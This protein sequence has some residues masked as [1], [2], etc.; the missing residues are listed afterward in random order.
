[1][2]EDN[3]RDAIRDLNMFRTIRAE[4][5]K[6]GYDCLE[7]LVFAP[8]VKDVIVK[9]MDGMITAR[10]ICHDLAVST[11]AAVIGEKALGGRDQS[12]LRA[13]FHQSLSFSIPPPTLYHNYSRPGAYSELVFGIP[14]ADL[15]TNLTRDKV[16]KVMMMCIKEVEKRGLQAKKIYSGNPLDADV[17]QLRHR[18]EN[19]K[20][21][22]FNSEDSIH[23][24]AM[25]LKLYLGDLPEPL[26]VFSLQDYRNYS[27]NR[28]KYIQNDF[29]LYRSK[30]SELHPVNKASL[31]ALYQHLFLVST[32]SSPPR[33]DKNAMTVKELAGE[34]IDCVLH[35]QGD[36]F[37]N[38]VKIHVMEDLIQNAH[39]LF[40]FKESSFLLPHHH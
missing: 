10:E 16:P 23:S 30:I 7:E 33:S 4:N 38:D 26:F 14:M 28:A 13:C 11:K 35:K 22:S 8:T 20:S 37:P 9:Y 1:V 31:G 12:D 19:E 25:L 15:E 32:Y 17:L 39:T 27:Q 2:S 21:F 5:L 29:S 6:D 18:F 34:F 40:K 24:I 3:L 36:H